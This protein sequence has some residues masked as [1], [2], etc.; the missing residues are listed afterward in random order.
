VLDDL[1]G[2]F[3]ACLQA[4]VAPAARRDVGLHHAL[5]AAF[6]VEIGSGVL[7]YVAYELVAP[8]WSIDACIDRGMTWASPLKV[9]VQLSDRATGNL[10]EQEIWFGEIPLMTSEGTF[11][12]DGE[13][14][15]LG[16]AAE[17]LA[18][19]LL[20]GAHDVAARLEAL[21]LDSIDGYMPHDL[22]NAKWFAMAVYEMF[23]RAKRVRARNP[24]TQLD[25]VLGRASS[26]PWASARVVVEPEVPIVE[27]G[28]EAEVARATG[29]VSIAGASG[30]LVV[31]ESGAVVVV[32]SDGSAA[33]A[34]EP[35]RWTRRGRRTVDRLVRSNGP[36][37]T[38]D[39]V[40]ECDGAKNGKLALGRN[41]RVRFDPKAKKAVV[42]ETF[43]R[44]MRASEVFVLDA[45]L[46]YVRDGKQTRT[47]APGLDESGIIPLGA[48]VKAG[49]LLV[50][51]TSP[52]IRQVDP[53]LVV[54]KGIDGRVV[55][56]QIRGKSM[57]PCA[58]QKAIDAEHA[59]TWEEIARIASEGSDP[60]WKK[61]A[62]ELEP[63]KWRRDDLPPNVHEL[64]RVTIERE[65]P[66][67]AKS[68]LGDR[69]GAAYAIA[70]VDSSLDVDAI[71]PGSPSAAARREID[72]GGLYLL[73]T[74]RATSR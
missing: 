47:T 8:K 27:M 64:A 66:L 34:I 10:I 69:H 30:E 12:I 36:V 52:D 38:G 51:I 68:R 32:P 57:D 59:R 53:S 13:E 20:K 46:E 2:A 43:A 25:H 37:K 21:K 26:E 56:V 55:R 58:R 41:A 15:V 29:L 44:A 42:S 72:A 14:R 63:P 54:K 3:A 28:D 19:A 40:F 61:L 16:D 45:H 7:V 62:E 5:R 60:R 31:L 18:R 74:G 1:L 11:V 35:R 33:F 23:G 24:M 39:V 67:E 9:S 17:S 4:D 70:R 48:S 6:P 73:H 65:I 22:V 50:G 71:L 49:D